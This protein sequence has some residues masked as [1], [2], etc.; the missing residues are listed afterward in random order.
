MAKVHR[1][2][3]VSFIEQQS[4]EMDQ[5][6]LKP[7]RKEQKE[8]KCVCVWGGV[9]EAC[10]LALPLLARLETLHK[11]GKREANSKQEER[12]RNIQKCIC[13]GEWRRK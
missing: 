9:A 6:T 7:Q 12:R 8:K 1:N 11:K 10:W 3:I 13:K 2:A 4:K 5:S